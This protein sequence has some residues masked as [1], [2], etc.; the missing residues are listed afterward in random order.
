MRAATVSATQPTLAAVLWPSDRALRHALLV[1]AGSVLLTLS[2]KVQIP[3][4]PVPMTMQTYVV[5]VLGMAYGTRLG[6]A[7]VLF[8][9][10][11]ACSRPARIGRYAGARHRSRL[12]DRPDRGLSSGICGG[13]RTRGRA[14]GPGLGSHLWADT[15]CH[16]PRAPRDIRAWRYL[17]CRIH[18]LGAG[19]CRRGR[20]IRLGHGCED[21]ARCGDP[22]AGVALRGSREAAQACI[23]PSRCPGLSRL[24]AI[25]G[26]A[27]PAAQHRRCVDARTDA[28]VGLRSGNVDVDRGL[29]G[30]IH[31]QIRQDAQA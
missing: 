7:T 14:G 17:A 1:A 23:G 9:L 27:E 31:E 20:S 3:F 5:L 4:W 15:D 16:G 24:S 19:I 22:S 25:S 11:Q 6:V 2:A 21:V 26:C 29:R 18:R 10:V 8:Y 13:R 28:D 30:G 12:H